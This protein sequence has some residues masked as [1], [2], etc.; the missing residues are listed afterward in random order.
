MLREGVYKKTYF[1][2]NSANGGR[3]NSPLSATIIYIYISFYSDFF[4]SKSYVLDHPESIDDAYREIIDEN[5]I[6]DPPRVNNFADMP[7]HAYIEVK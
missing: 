7:I 4:L 3:V 5:P 2:K 6:F 1:C